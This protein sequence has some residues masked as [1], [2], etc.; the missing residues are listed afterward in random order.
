MSGRNADKAKK[1]VRQQLTDPTA[2]AMADDHIGKL[3]EATYVATGDDTLSTMAD[4]PLLHWGSDNPRRI[5]DLTMFV[6]KCVIP[7]EYHVWRL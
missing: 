6:G 2:N 5:D 1:I 3:T 7:Y 4:T